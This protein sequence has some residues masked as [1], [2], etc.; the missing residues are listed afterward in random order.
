[1]V[2]Y[3]ICERCGLVFQSPRMTNAALDDYYAAEYRQSVQ[4]S[5]EPTEKD[6]RMQHA[7]ANHFLE[8]TTPWIRTV[9]KCLDVGSSTGILL[10]TFRNSYQCNGVGIEPG[11]AYANFSREKGFLVLSDIKHLEGVHENSF[12]LITLGHTLEHIPDPFD[13]LKTL[14]ERWLSPAG[15]IL[16]EVP[17]LYGHHSFEQAHLIAFSK[18]TLLELL[19]QTGFQVLKVRVH[20][21]PRSRLIPLYITVL[22]K[23][24]ELAA[25]RNTVRS[26]S[27]GVKAR[28]KV[29]MLWRQIATQLLPRWAWLPWPEVRQG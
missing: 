3:R 26:S 23:G 19:R 24:N 8:F 25:E 10:E 6:I 9:T 13:F 11:E 7:R 20:G 29:G 28:R 21:T 1:M 5:S 17:N 27:N 16:L 22:A 2:H 15:H 12:D 14:R 18:A 4:G